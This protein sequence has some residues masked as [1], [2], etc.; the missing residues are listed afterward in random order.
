MNSLIYM[1]IMAFSLSADAVGIGVSY[2][3]RGIKLSFFAKVIICTISFAIILISMLFGN[4]LYGFASEYTGR[5]IGS[6][7]L[8]AAGVWII[9]QGL[10]E[11]K[12]KRSI[13]N[14]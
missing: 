4:V 2:G 1:V 10:T 14:L 6:L 7:I 5:I 9:L 12:K 13:L 11:K 8:F 3:I